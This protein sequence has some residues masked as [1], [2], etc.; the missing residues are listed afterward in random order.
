M[1]V[2][3]YTTEF[4][5]DGHLTLPPTMLPDIDLRQP[6]K[7]RVLI[8]YEETPPQKTLAHFGGRW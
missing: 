3:E 1:K 8:I 6:K 7:V 4:S 5:P 2:I